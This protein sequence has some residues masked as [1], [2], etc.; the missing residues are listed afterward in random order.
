MRFTAK[1]RFLAAFL[2]GTALLPGAASAQLW[3][4]ETSPGGD[5]MATSGRQ[6][7]RIR[8]VTPA[9]LPLAEVPVA[10]VGGVPTAGWTPP[11]LPQ[12]A[13]PPAPA[14][15]SAARSRGRGTAVAA[16]RIA[17]GTVVARRPVTGARNARL[18]NDEAM[19]RRLAAREAELDRLRRRL[20]DD[21][22]R[23]DSQR[24]NTALRST[25]QPASPALTR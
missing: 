19:Q 16:P 1:A 24:A 9:P 23:Y 7:D 3:P 12:Q 18:Q 20:D 5:L 17:P 13:T 22:N 14:R 15:R 2:I 8:A 4:N 6:F 11:P 25:P 10:S 21:R